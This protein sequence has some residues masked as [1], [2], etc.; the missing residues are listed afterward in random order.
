MHGFAHNRTC[1]FRLAS[2][3]KLLC[4]FLYLLIRQFTEKLVYHYSSLWHY[5]RSASTL[6][7]ITP[8]RP[9][10]PH[11]VTAGTF[12][13]CFCVK[14]TKNAPRGILMPSDPLLV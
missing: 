3:A 11:L 13:Q 4:M 2:R 1:Q 12:V 10:A 5:L 6:L 7:L 14:A 9:I 8:V